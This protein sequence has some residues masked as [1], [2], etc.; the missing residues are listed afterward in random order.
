M[1]ITYDLK[2]NSF[3]NINLLLGVFQTKKRLIKNPNKKILKASTIALILLALTIFSFILFGISVYIKQKS[4][5]DLF[6]FIFVFLFLYTIYHFTILITTY[7][8]YKTFVKGTIFINEKGI[9][10]EY[11][12]GTSTLIPWEHVELIIIKNNTLIITTKIANAA[13]LASIENKD[14]KE[15]ITLCKN[16]KSNILIINKMEK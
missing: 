4:L 14:I 2:Q 8:R 3:K 6:Y 7:H 13:L 11:D 10:N 9:K 16:N 12:N 15:F 5:Q 1:K